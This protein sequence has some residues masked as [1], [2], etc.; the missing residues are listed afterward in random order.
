METH[1]VQ[2]KTVFQPLTAN[3]YF[4]KESKCTFATEEIHYLGH[5]ILVYGVSVDPRKINNIIVWP[6]PTTLIK[7]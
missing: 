1:P 3:L 4:A 7:L 6:T 2:L 5:L